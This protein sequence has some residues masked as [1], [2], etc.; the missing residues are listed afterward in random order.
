MEI[1]ITSEWSLEEYKLSNTTH[2]QWDPW[3]LKPKATQWQNVSIPNESRMCQWMLD[4]IAFV[5]HHRCLHLMMMNRR[6]HHHHWLCCH[7]ALFLFLAPFCWRFNDREV[8]RAAACK[9]T[10]RPTPK[11]FWEIFWERFFGRIDVTPALNLQLLW[12]FLSETR[13]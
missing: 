1:N 6:R 9:R 3:W 8:M 2:F 11:I 13:E 5:L 10:F 7:R 4:I 12:L